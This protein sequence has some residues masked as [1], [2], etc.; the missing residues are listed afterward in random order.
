[1]KT[2]VVMI[3]LL[4]VCLPA[5]LSAA[6]AAQG[7]VAVYVSAPMKD[8]F[9]DTDKDT[10]DSVKDVKGRLSGMNEFRIATSRE[11][12]DVVLTV[13]M[14]DTGS[15]AF[16]QRVTY[17]GYSNSYY[18]NAQLTST[19]MVA[20]TRWVTA[21]MEVGEYRKEFTGTSHTI[22]GARMGTWTECAKNLAKDLKAWVV[23]NRE[24]LLERRAD[25]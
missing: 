3:L 17:S 8:G 1:M 6:K 25:R 9:V 7:A 4:A 19:P 23:A 21:V 2:R 12:A 5:G 16:G 24:Q 11:D 10:Q 22:P 20:Q 18:Q 14:R 15:S 13:L